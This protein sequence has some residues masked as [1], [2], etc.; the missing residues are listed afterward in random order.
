MHLHFVDNYEE[1]AI[2]QID[3]P[4]FHKYLFTYLGWK[5]QSV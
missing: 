1:E 4:D 5:W 3:L 2:Y